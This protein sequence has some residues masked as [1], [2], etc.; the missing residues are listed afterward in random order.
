VILTQ[1]AQALLIATMA[2]H[3]TRAFVK[4]KDFLMLHS[5][6][7]PAGGLNRLTRKILCT[8]LPK[9]PFRILINLWQ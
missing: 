2:S 4:T 6:C 3:D 5:V 8:V 7:D 1:S 9:P